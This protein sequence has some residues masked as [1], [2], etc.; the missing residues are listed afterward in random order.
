MT[1]QTATVTFLAIYEAMEK[2]KVLAAKEGWT[3]D[4]SIADYIDLHD[5][6][7]DLCRKFATEQAAI[8]WLKQEITALNTVF[9]CGEI[10]SVEKVEPARRCKYCTCRG[11]KRVSRILVDDDGPTS[12]GPDY[13]DDC[14]N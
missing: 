14:H 4:E 3:E 5:G 2:A 6:S 8:D 9:G 10:I 11:Q 7:V 1:A 13:F 12:D